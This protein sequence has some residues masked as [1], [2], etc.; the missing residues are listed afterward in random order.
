MEETRFDQ[1]VRRLTNAAGRREASRSLGAAGMALAAVLGLR[2]G[3]AAGKERHR[4]GG[5]DGK[6]GGHDGKNRNRHRRRQD[7]QPGQTRTPAE[8]ADEARGPGEN[9]GQAGGVAAERKRKKKRGPTGPTG[10]T[11]PAGGGTGAGAT[12]ATGPTGR[13][14]PTGPAGPTGPTGPTGATGPNFDSVIEQGD[15]SDPLGTTQG[16][17]VSSTA[18][19]DTGKLLGGGYSVQA[20]GEQAFN[21]FVNLS[22]PNGDCYTAQIQ[23]TSSTGNVAG[24]TVLAFAVCRP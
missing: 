7:N 13:T 12:G 2:T 3:G 20:S 18:C 10:P 11:G 17:V 22:R 6:G 1:S 8:G 15:I 23:R 9:P 21:V 19:C 5:A 16:Q 24:A 4:R 14:G